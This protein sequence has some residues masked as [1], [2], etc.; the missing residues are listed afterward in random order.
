MSDDAL[1]ACCS[2]AGPGRCRGSSPTLSEPAGG[3]VVDDLDQR[4]DTGTRAA[5]RVYPNA[6]VAEG[7]TRDVQVHPP[8][9]VRDEL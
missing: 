3:D 4:S 2:A 5:L 7:R 9:A 6:L 8:D 1:V